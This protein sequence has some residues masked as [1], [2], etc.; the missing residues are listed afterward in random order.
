MK[1]RNRG[2][3]T[4]GSGVVQLLLPHR[5]PFLMVDGVD[6]FQR[7]DPPRLQAHRSISINESVFDGHFPEMPLWPGALTM[8][9]LGQS[10]VL[11]LALSRLCDAAEAS[12][13]TSEEVLSELAN[14]D[15]AYRLHPGYRPD[16]MPEVLHR[17]GRP[18]T[19]AVGA[20]VDIKFLAP[21][22]PGSR[23]DYSVEITDDL[24]DRVCF[25][26]EASV[27]GTTVARGTITGALVSAP[28]LPGAE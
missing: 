18:D 6:G 10:G 20:A 26:A 19:L 22:L 2:A 4:L 27:D 7:D 13:A 1:S 3:F 14:L 15:R 17:I 16:Q 25:A 11:L 21:V 5:R 12:G 28:P 8:E 23:L 9:G 24:G